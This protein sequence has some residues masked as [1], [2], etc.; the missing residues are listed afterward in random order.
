MIYFPETV[1][2]PFDAWR[3]GMFMLASVILAGWGIKTVFASFLAVLS[4]SG[5]D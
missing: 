3:V 5:K 4:P 2:S 1:T